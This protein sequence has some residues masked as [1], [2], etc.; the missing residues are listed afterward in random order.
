M[1]HRNRPPKIV[2]ADNTI[3][4][5]P[6]LASNTG[7]STMEQDDKPQN[8]DNHTIE[9]AGRDHHQSNDLPRKRIENRL[10]PDKDGRDRKRHGDPEDRRDPC[11][12]P[13]FPVA[14]GW[15]V[16]PPG[17]DVTDLSTDRPELSSGTA[18]GENSRQ[19]QDERGVSRWGRV[20]GR[21]EMAFLCQ[22]PSVFVSGWR[23]L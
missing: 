13:Q 19:A 18:G 3:R 22:P 17:T 11:S 16:T 15:W 21:T 9:N 5:D 10:I 12:L 14:G 1:N 2:V 8:R 23:D 6:H 4:I 7:C 20:R